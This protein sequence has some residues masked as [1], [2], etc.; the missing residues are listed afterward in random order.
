MYMFWMSIC[1]QAYCLSVCLL[2][3]FDTIY[4][5]EIESNNNAL[6]TYSRHR[7]VDLFILSVSL[8]SLLKSALSLRN[9]ESLGSTVL[10]LVTIPYRTISYSKMK[11][12]TRETGQAGGRG[13]DGGKGRE[14]ERVQSNCVSV[15][16]F[17]MGSL[18]I[19]RNT[20]KTIDRSILRFLD[21]TRQPYGE[22]RSR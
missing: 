14:R 18:G 17:V 6:L 11:K 16:S 1:L 21:E 20:R 5:Y 22:S 3:F 4:A 12:E 15:L 9:A 7:P 13:G 2:N 8:I 10:G 19:E